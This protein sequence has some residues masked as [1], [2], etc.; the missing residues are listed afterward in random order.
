MLMIYLLI[1]ISFRS[2]QILRKL[3]QTEN[4]MQISRDHYILQAEAQNW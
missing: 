1:T 2:A 4:L 3:R